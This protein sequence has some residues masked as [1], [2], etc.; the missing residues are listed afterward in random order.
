VGVTLDL[1]GPVASS[2][3]ALFDLAGRRIA[4][5]YRGPIGPGFHRY[6]WAAQSRRPGIYFA[7]ALV[8]GTVLTTRV[9]VLR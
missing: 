1:P 9:L 7:R 2:D 6:A 4:T 8:D 3:V 5:L